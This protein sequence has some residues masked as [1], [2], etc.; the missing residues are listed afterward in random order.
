MRILNF[1]FKL[2]R[3]TADARKLPSLRTSVR[4]QALVPNVLLMPPSLEL[5]R[6]WEDVFEDEHEPGRLISCLQA[7]SHQ[8]WTNETLG[9]GDVLARFKCMDF[10]TSLSRA[11]IF[12]LCEA[13]TVE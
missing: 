6:S 12:Y 3:K 10:A 4:D 2:G 7:Q 1:P 13:F 11:Y 9:A 5:N 8:D